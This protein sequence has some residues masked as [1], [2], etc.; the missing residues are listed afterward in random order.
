MRVQ[1]VADR[2][3]GARWAPASLAS[4][5]TRM[6]F[7]CRTFVTLLRSDADVFDASNQ[8]VYPVVWLA[9]KLRR[10]RVVFWF[11]DLFGGRASVGF[12]G[13][14]AHVLAA[15]EWI[16]LHLPVDRYIAISSSTLEKLVDRGVPATPSISS[17]A[18][19]TLCSLRRFGPASRVTGTAGIVAPSSSSSV[20]W[21][22]T[23]AWIWSSEH[24]RAWSTTSTECT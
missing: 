14:A 1:Y 23:S 6:W 4:I 2:T 24:W 17:R 13:V 9:A 15:A 22:R 16:A 12:L 5:P 10:R 7:L 21:W 3:D 11:P 20:G 19:S 18:G 8:T